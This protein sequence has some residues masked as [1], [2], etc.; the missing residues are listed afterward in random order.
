MARFADLG[1]D[2]V[3]ISIQDS[4]EKNA[5][6]IGGYQDGFA[7]KLR[8][9]K[10]VRANGLPLTLNAPV[11][12]MNIHNLECIIDLAVEMEASRLEVAHVQYYGWGLP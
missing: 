10:A 11:H 3:Q 12:K 2:H 6:H 4:E 5:N 8:V 7:Q 1:L 9:A